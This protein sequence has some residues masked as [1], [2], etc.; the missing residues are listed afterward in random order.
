MDVKSTEAVHPL[1][2]GE[3]VKGHFAG[4]SNKLEK[5]GSFFL[6][7]GADSTPEPLNLCRRG[8]VIMILGIVPPII[9]VNIWETRD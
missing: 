1:E 3:T 5:L 9:N 7:K 2:L 4:T 6:I 8:R